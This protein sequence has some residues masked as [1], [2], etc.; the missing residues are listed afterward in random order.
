MHGEHDVPMAGHCGERTTRM[1]IGK[2]FYW[3]EMKHDVEHFMCIYVKCQNTKS[4]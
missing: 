2:I 4:I 1:A 3:L